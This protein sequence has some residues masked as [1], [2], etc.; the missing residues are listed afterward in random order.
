LTENYI[1]DTENTEERKYPQMAQI[2][3]DKKEKGMQPKKRRY[4]DSF[5]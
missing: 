3:A 5:F 4:F 1:A 2:L